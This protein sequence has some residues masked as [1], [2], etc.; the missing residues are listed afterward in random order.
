MLV[1]VGLSLAVNELSC[2]K[3]KPEL[4]A[5]SKLCRASPLTNRSIV[6]RRFAFRAP[7]TFLV[8]ILPLA[9]YISLNRW[10]ELPT[11]RWRRISTMTSPSDRLEAVFIW[12]LMHDFS[13]SRTFQKLVKRFTANP[14][15]WTLCVMIGLHLDLLEAPLHCWLCCTTHY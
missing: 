7:A 1:A 14:L 9:K 15:W 2:S 11:V 4:V 13:L 6:G 5:T 10:K 8:H 3:H 12:L